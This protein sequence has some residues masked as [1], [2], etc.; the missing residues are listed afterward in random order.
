VSLTVL[1]P[2]L[3]SL[4]VDAGRP[5]ARH[6]GVPVGGPADAA[7]FAVG[8]A[9]VGNGPDAV[10]L[11]MSFA[12]PT[13]RAEVALGA[14]IV[15]APFAAEIVGQRTPEPGVGFTLAPGDVLKIGGT[16]RGARAYLCVPGGFRTPDGLGSRSGF[17]PVTTGQSLSCA[18]SR[19]TAVSVVWELPVSPVTVRVLPGPQYD[20][21]LDPR[22]FTN[23]R[24]EVH[25]ASDR[26]GLRLNGPMLT[27]RAGELTS[28]PVA[29]GAVQVTNDGRPVVLGVDGQTIGGYPKIA[30]VVRADLD[31]L[32][33]LRPGDRLRFRFV[34]PDEATAAAEERDRRI[35]EWRVRIETRR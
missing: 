21:F 13:L 17:G 31:L 5:G 28:E 14:V 1:N 19:I 10:A 35:H 3:H 11:E 20:W 26:M 25:P 12:G 8:H 22:E 15:G 23:E 27:R 16:A 4:L 7:A 18:P 33:Q 29:P 6:L 9:L 24:Y 34:T 2:G 32:G 30:H